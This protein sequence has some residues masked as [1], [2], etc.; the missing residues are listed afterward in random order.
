MITQKGY[1]ELIKL[2]SIRTLRVFL[3][4]VQLSDLNNNITIKQV[5][6]SKLLNLKNKANVN[7]AIKELLE[8]DFIRKKAKGKKITYILNPGF[9]VTQK[10]Y[11]ELQEE[12]NVLEEFDFNEIF[13]DLKGVDINV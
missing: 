3:K 2:E 13:D 1:E 4:L 11:E 10:G 9:V 8:K 7:V 6:L 12:Y 5:E